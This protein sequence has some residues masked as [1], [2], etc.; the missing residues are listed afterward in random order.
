[1]H[2]PAPQ[3]VRIQCTT[4]HWCDFSCHP[5]DDYVLGTP[6]GADEVT[7]WQAWRAYADPLKGLERIETYTKWVLGANALVVSLAGSLA[8]GGVVTPATRTAKLLYGV[9]IALLGLSW[10]AVSLSIAPKWA[11]INRQSPSDFVAGFNEQYRS[12]RGWLAL[13]SIALGLALLSAAIVPVADRT[14][15]AS[16]SSAGIDYDMKQGGTVEARLSGS[17]LPPHTPV[18]LA[19]R[20][21]GPDYLVLRQKRVLVDS[22]GKVDM[23]LVLDSAGAAAA[24]KPLRITGNWR[25]WPGRGTQSRRATVPIP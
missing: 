7:Q 3:V 16:I 1:M 12:R 8:A 10:A 18:E 9:A 13:A 14:Q 22:I 15:E 19:I 11:R 24:A 17:G 6:V 2:E 4:D 21:D 25:V 20:S 23:S 5:S